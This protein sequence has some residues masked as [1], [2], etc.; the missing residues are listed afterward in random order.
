MNEGK[1]LNQLS[2][3]IS[4]KHNLFSKHNLTLQ[5]KNKIQIYKNENSPL[6][7]EFYQHHVK[8]SSSILFI[9]GNTGEDK[10]HFFL[11]YKAYLN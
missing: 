10:E 11:S 1:R 3:R 4:N 9:Q 2:D 7:Q 6:Y 8:K 5:E